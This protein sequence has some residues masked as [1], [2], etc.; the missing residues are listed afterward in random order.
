MGQLNAGIV[1]VTPFQQNCTILFD[2]DDK[3]GVVVDPGGDVDT[4]LSVLK[5]NGITI[6]AIWLT[7][8]HID[9]AGGAM[10]LKDT[11]GVD[12]IGPHEADK[13]LLDNLVTQAQKFGM[14]GSVRNCVPDRF[15]T[16]GETV[17][18]GT[19]V[20][21]VLHCPGHAPGHVVFYNR[22]AKFAHVGDVLFQG[23]VGRT[24]LYGGDHATLIRSIKEKLLPLGDEIGFI[25]G[26]GPGSRFGDE[27]RSNPYLV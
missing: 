9:H 23:S 7:H 15:L 8:G 6:T 21:E 3:T 2:T 4:I 24:D 11:L 18:F 10:E 5:Q 14:D 22:D 26:H 13:P 27:R 1:P 19:H 17:S 20:F 25:C 16:E 12:I